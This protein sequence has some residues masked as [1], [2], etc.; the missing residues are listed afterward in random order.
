MTNVIKGKN[1]PMYID[2]V[3]IVKDFSYRNIYNESRAGN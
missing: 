2:L 1:I 3:T